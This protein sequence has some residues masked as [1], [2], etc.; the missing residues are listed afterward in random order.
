MNIH[1]IGVKHFSRRFQI[2]GK[3]NLLLDKLIPSQASTEEGVETI[4]NQRKAKR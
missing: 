2:R 4:R 3:L 1:I